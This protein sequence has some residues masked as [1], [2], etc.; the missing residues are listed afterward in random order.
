MP[1]LPVPLRWW[2]DG[3]RYEVVRSAILRGLGFLYAV[4][5]VSLFHQLPGLFGRDGILPVHLFLDRVREAV[6]HPAWELPS[7]FWWIGPTDGTMRALAA[8]G[9][10][11]SILAIAGVRHPALFA[12]LWAL[13]LSFVSVGQI[14]YGYGWEM[15]LLEAGA[16]AMFL[17]PW[18]RKRGCVPAR[19]RALPLAP[20]AAL[21]RRRAHQ[22]PRRRRAGGI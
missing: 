20:R 22:A 4:A 9:G 13:Y 12:I 8:I 3:S 16:L 11:L 17:A 2:L 10:V 19:H 5:F 6:Q 7:L 14:F 18:R 21:A 1:N 15:L